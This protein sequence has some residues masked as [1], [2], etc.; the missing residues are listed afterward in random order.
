MN[1]LIKIIT[2]MLVTFL[3]TKISSAE[4]LTDQKVKEII[5]GAPLT[6]NHW[7]KW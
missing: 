3:I 5:S 4:C 1:K 2:I 6:P 7:Y